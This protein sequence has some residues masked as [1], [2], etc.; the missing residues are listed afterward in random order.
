[1]SDVFAEMELAAQRDSKASEIAHALRRWATERLN[2][3]AEL[4]ASIQNS[5]SDHNRWATE[6]LNL[7][8]ELAAMRAELADEKK[9]HKETW[10][11]LEFVSRQLAEAKRDFES[12]MTKA[13]QVNEQRLD[14]ITALR[15]VTNG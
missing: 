4:A 8:A 13:L 9:S 11:E 12:R 5:A 15:E 10:N 3:E 14:E 2:L 6:R 1:M 7:I